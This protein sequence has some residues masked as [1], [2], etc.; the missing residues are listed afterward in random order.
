M[1]SDNETSTNK[2]CDSASN[3]KYGSW[4]MTKSLE[5]LK[6]MKSADSPYMK[7]IEEDIQK[8]RAHEMHD[9]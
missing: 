5:E 3:W 4:L 7:L 1:S 6:E 2:Y 8:W 9:T